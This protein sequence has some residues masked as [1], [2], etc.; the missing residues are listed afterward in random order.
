[1][2]STIR[3]RNDSDKRHLVTQLSATMAANVCAVHDRC[4]DEKCRRRC[5]ARCPVHRR[6]RTSR[7][8]R[9]V[10]SIGCLSFNSDRNSLHAYERDER[11]I[12]GRVPTECDDAIEWARAQDEYFIR[13][14]LVKPA[15]EKDNGRH[16]KPGNP[17]LRPHIPQ[18]LRNFRRE[19][20]V[21]CSVLRIEK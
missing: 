14:D 15:H 5:T 10:A 19:L 8:Q 16:G 12:R 6:E 9:S 21:P 3:S 20:G 11:P 17:G 7:A 13:C 2:R 1:M 4:D 18:D